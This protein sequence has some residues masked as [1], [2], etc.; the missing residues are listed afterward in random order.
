[1]RHWGL[2]HD[3]FVQADSPYVSLPSHDEAVARLVCAIESSQRRAILAGPAGVGKTTVLRQA[4]SEAKSP[5]R[6]FAAVSCPSEGTL[7]FTL[8]A[9]R[10][11]QRVGREPNRLG[12]WRA[13]E[14]A[15]HLASLQGMQIVLAIDDCDA[16]VDQTT[17][18]DLDSLAHVGSTANTE[19][20][21]IQLERTVED[22]QSVACGTWSRASD[23]ERLTR[24]Q[25]ERYL[26]TKI[27][28]AGRTERIFTTRAITRL[29]ALSSGV[30][31]GL[32]QLA[33][34]CLMAGA[35]RRLELIHSD[36]VD[37][38]A[39]ACETDTLPT[40]TLRISG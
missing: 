36:L 39:P 16:R 21:V 1:M 15:V 22:A 14:R 20:T 25:A 17:R 6:R 24:S 32:E 38:V 5:R 28:R 29:H 7:L 9:E 26:A 23:V 4:L 27:E 13:L 31:R 2:A 40:S 12:A 19:L 3:P 33:S 30:P 18:R 34:L 37:A 10:L 8:L 35:V 11:G